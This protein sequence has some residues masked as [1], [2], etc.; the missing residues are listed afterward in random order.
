MSTV[1]ETFT[2]TTGAAWSASNWEGLATI[3]AST[4]TIQA[5]AGQMVAAAAYGSVSRRWVMA[6]RA[7][8]DW[9]ITVTPGS[10]AQ[11]TY[12]GIYVRAAATYGGN[13]GDV[14]VPTTGYGFVYT[15]NTN[16]IEWWSYTSLSRTLL[17]SGT[18]TWTV[19]A[20][21][22]RVAIADQSMAAKLWLASSAEPGPW[23]LTATDGAYSTGR[24]VLNDYG[25][26]VGTMTL[27][28]DNLTDNTLAFPS[29]SPR[30][31]RTLMRSR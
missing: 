31:R 4:S 28:F 25:G 24:M 12:P 5:N 23:N 13:G 15:I 3:G 8:Q 6:D 9:T 26:N 10:V 19:A 20:Y 30:V 18:F 2:G 27:T 1:V 14:T 17:A 11:E 7:R 22:I 16:T 29:P 21:K